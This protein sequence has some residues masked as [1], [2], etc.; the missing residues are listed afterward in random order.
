MENLDNRADAFGARI[1]ARAARVVRA[2]H[3]LLINQE[4]NIAKK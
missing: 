1:A 3:E 4:T 2:P